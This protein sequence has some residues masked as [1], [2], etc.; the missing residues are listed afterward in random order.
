MNIDITFDCLH[1]PGTKKRPLEDGQVGRSKKPKMTTVVWI[2]TSL[3]FYPCMP[4]N[5]NAVSK[6]LQRGNDRHRVPVYTSAKE[7][8]DQIL[9]NPQ[10]KCKPTFLVLSKKD[11][12]PGNHLGKR[13]WMQITADRHVLSLKETA[14]KENFVNICQTT[15]PSAE[16]AYIICPGQ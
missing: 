4:T 9:Q 6:S 11:G 16:R 14:V 2:S 1:S 15:R 8:L 3:D 10:C 13:V 12:C 5:C 7:N